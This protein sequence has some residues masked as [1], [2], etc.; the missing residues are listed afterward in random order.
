MLTAW[1]GLETVVREIGIHFVAKVVKTF[2]VLELIAKTLDEFR[3]FRVP[4]VS[5][6][7]LAP[8]LHEERALGHG[9]LDFYLPVSVLGYR[10][11]ATTLVSE[12]RTQYYGLKK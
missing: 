3:Y 8:S 2:G 10:K 4:K 1:T 5:V 12:L 6:I 7:E 9:T 11:V